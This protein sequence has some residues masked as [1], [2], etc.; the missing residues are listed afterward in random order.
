[1]VVGFYEYVKFQNLF[2]WE[3]NEVFNTYSFQKIILLYIN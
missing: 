3:I 1:V 2:Q